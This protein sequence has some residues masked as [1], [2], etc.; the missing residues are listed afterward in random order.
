MN[1]EE[2]ICYNL[3]ELDNFYKRYG[4]VEKEN[5]QFILNY[6]GSEGYDHEEEMYRV[7]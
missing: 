6:L 5:Y 3:E 1:Y 2:I 4:E 7:R